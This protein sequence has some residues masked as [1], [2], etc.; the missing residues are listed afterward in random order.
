MIYFFRKRSNRRCRKI[1]TMVKR[2]GW[3]IRRSSWIITFSEI[4]TVK[5]FSRKE[6]NTIMGGIYKTYFYP[7]ISLSGNG[8]F[9]WTFLWYDDITN[10]CCM[11]CFI[12]FFILLIY[13]V[14]MF[15][16]LLKVAVSYEILK[17]NFSR[18]ILHSK[19]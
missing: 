13:T 17:I 18:I 11:Y 1:I 8:I 7:P 19:Y 2:L 15:E 14:I 10:I 3:T 9:Y 5:Q 6:R 12:G 16:Y 4:N